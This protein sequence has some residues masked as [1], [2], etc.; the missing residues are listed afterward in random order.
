M[1]R[2][3]LALLATT[4]LPAYAETMPSGEQIYTALVIDY[5]GELIGHG[6]AVVFT[7][8]PACIAAMN[9]LSDSPDHA[10][11]EAFRCVQFYLDAGEL[12]VY[13]PE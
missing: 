9:A 6:A 5:G 3:A 2:I 1:P 10:G 11:A 8:Y 13:Q 4:C 12:V 7:E